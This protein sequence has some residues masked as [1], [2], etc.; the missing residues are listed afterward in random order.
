VLRRRLVDLALEWQEKYGVAPSITSS[1]SEYDAAMLV[2]M[3][4]DEYSHYMQDKTAVA[5]GHDF[6]FNG[7]RYQIK[8]TRPSG[9]QGSKITNV[10]NAKNRNW[11]KIIW[12]LYDKE[13]E[14][15]EA[16]EWDIEAYNSAFQHNQRLSPKHYREGKCLYS[17]YS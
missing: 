2:G 15:I 17:K 3:T 12:V 6:I 10:P 16:W 7:I 11:D 14:M 8:A 4:E 9:K 13:Y 5:K 1:V